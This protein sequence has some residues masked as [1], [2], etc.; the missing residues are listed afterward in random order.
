MVDVRNGHLVLSG[1]GNI[2]S[3]N[4]VLGKQSASDI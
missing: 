2:S 4:V 1:L 3:V